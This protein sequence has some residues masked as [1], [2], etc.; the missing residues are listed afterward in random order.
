VPG[1][2]LRHDPTT[3]TLIEDS[4]MHRTRI[5]RS[6]VALLPTLLAGCGAEGVTGPSPQPIPTVTVITVT[7]ANAIDVGRTSTMTATARRTDGTTE[8]VTSAATWQ[9]SNPAVAQVNARGVVS[10]VAAGSAVVSASVSAVTGQLP[11]QVTA[12]DN[13]Q[14]VEVRVEEVL[15]HGTCD[16]NS[17]FEGAADGEFSFRF[18]LIRGGDRVTL[19]FTQREPYARGTHPLPTRPSLVFKRNITRGDEFRVEF[20]ATEH[21]GLLGPDP[22]LP[23][24]GMTRSHVFVNGQWSGGREF[25]LGTN[26]CSVGVVYSIASRTAEATSA[27][28]AD[29]H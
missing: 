6:L 21:D 8:D 17:L 27:I 16:E 4:T 12:V 24:G 1:I 22:R 2:P 7:G 18:D 19:W 28:L 9:S 29:A 3:Y 15:I 11:I 23:G 13:V 14:D 25:R 26:P 10:A 20:V 5:A